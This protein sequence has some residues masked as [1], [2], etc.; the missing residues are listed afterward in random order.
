MTDGCHGVPEFL[1]S[2]GNVVETVTVHL[3]SRQAT[4]ISHGSWG[5]HIVPTDVKGGG[6][7]ADPPAT[8]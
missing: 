8:E 4:G 3:H 6:P 2:Y 5:G 1:D 7:P